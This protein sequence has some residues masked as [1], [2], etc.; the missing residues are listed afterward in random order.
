VKHHLPI[1]STLAVLGA[2]AAAGCGG[3]DGGGDD[4]AE[5]TVRDVQTRFQELTGVELQTSGSGLGSTTLQIPRGGEDALLFSQRYSN[6]RI[7][8]FDDEDDFERRRDSGIGGEAVAVGNV[9]VRG[10]YGSDDTGFRRAVPIVQSLGKPVSAVRLAPEDTPCARAGIDPDGGTTRTGTCLLGPR[11]VTV[12][13]NDEELRLPTTTISRVR[14]R[15]ADSLARPSF[16]GPS[17]RLRPRGRFV[18]VTAR[19][20]NTS[21]APIDRLEANLIIDGRLYSAD[22]TA[23]GTLE[24]RPFPLQPGERVDVTTFFDVPTAVRDPRAEGALQLA[25]T[26]EQFQSPERALSVGRVRLE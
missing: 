14:T 7:D 5:F 3:S 20:E 2:L 10:G 24:E 25:N 19:V 13:G 21:N 22:N 11:T 18:I 8:V 1:V 23:E 17:R 15:T 9:L 6:V 4:F 26:E 12:V 16:G